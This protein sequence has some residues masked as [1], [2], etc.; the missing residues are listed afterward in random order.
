MVVAV[1]DVG[2]TIGIGSCDVSTFTTI[3]ASDSHAPR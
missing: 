2:L 3:E 1:G